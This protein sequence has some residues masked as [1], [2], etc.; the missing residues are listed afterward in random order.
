MIEL[1]AGTFHV[2]R[3]L[4][5]TNLDVTIRGAG[6]GE[7]TVLADGRFNPDGL[8]QRIPPDEAAALRSLDYPFLFLFHGATSTDLVHPSSAEASGS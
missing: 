6:M 8:F 3:P 4:I 5:G 1:S 7:I 2:G